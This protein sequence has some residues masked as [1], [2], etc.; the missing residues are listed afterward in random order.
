MSKRVVLQLPAVPDSADD[1]MRD[2]LAAVKNQLEVLSGA[3]NVEDKRPTVQDMIDA[4]ITNAD[5][6]S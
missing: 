2:F 4:N 1:D 6:I 5:K 3:G